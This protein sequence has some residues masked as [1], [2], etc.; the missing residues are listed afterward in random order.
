MGKR[1][2]SRG[3]TITQADVTAY[4][5]L[6]GNWSGIYTDQ[7]AAAKSKY[8]RCIVPPLAVVMMAGGI[9]APYDVAGKAFYGIDVMD[10]IRP[11]FTGDTI[12]VEYEV[13]DRLEKKDNGVITTAWEIKN[14]HRD[15]VAIV[16]SKLAVFKR[17]TYE[18][19]IR[20]I[21]GK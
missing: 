9:I 18:A 15:T 20:K 8:G 2:T 19:L 14:Q 16:H 4:C 7:T 17:R 10:I 11:L 5:M 6:S 13:I 21:N 3:R 1:Y 12:H